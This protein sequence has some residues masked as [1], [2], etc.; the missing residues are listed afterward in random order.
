MIPKSYTK[1]IALFQSTLAATLASLSST[2]N[3][4]LIVLTLQ[5][6]SPPLLRK[7][8]AWLKPFDLSQVRRSAPVSS[9]STLRKRAPEDDEEGRVPPVDA[10][11]K[12]PVVPSGSTCFTSAEDVNNQT[13]ECLGRGTAVL[14]VSSRKGECWVCSCRATF[15]EGGKKTTWKGEGCEKIDLSS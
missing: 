10:K 1:A 15:D 7:R 8:A 6:Y 12:S 14:G 5:P 11:T 4:E 3:N 13:A 9:S 2:S